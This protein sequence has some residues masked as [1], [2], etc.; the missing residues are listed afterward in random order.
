MNK[1]SIKLFGALAIITAVILLPISCKKPTDGLVLTLNTDISP[2]IYTFKVYDAN[3]DNT[4]T[5]SEFFNINITGKDANMIYTLNGT[6]N[7]KFVKGYLTIMAKPGF[8][9]SPTKPLQFNIIIRYKNYLKTTVPV[10]LSRPN[11]AVVEVPIINTLNPPKGVSITNTTISTN[12]TTK[13]L[14]NEVKIKTPIDAN[15]K[16]ST[17]VTF[18]K[19][20]SFYD[21]KGN[22]VSGDINIQI[23]HF[24]NRNSSSL[25]AFPGGFSAADVFNNSNQSIGGGLFQTAGFVALEMSSQ[26]TE[27]SSFSQP[28]V[29]S[30]SINSDLKDPN[31]NQP[32]KDGDII[33]IW[34]FDSETGQWQSMD[35]STIR[36]DANSQQYYADFSTTRRTWYN[37]DYF[38]RSCEFETSVKLSYSGVETFCRYQIEYEN[39]RFSYLFY[40]PPYYTDLYDNKIITLPRGLAARENIRIRFF[41]ANSGDEIGVTPYFQSCYGLYDFTMESNNPNPVLEFSVYGRCPNT[42]RIFRPS[43]YIYFKDATS[44]DWKVLGY[45]SN[46]FIRTPALQQ[47]KTYTVG[48]ENA[49]EWY[50]TEVTIDNELTSAEVEWVLPEDYSGCK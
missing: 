38:F 50:S 43:G 10:Y 14:D 29:I 6:K 32:I 27:I 21:S 23:V 15:K 41:D 49:G 35:N 25:A 42:E 45:M 12:S 34:S 1:Y 2:V 37:Y 11:K 9:L 22:P 33:P 36:Y 46:G 7:F 28:A 5:E 31:T 30:T 48:T 47:G 26:G 20:T 13:Q 4:L 19:K 18:P 16:E 39:D 24:D 17:E 40:T 8:T 3:P 44:T